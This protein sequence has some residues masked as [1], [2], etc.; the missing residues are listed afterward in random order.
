LHV[1]SG[2]ARSKKFLVQAYPWNGGSF[3]GTLRNPCRSATYNL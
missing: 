3:H 2:C 1:G